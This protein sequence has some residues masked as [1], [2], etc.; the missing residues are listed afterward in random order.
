MTHQ[1]LAELGDR[2]RSIVEA[3][4]FAGAD[5]PSLR[6]LGR[7]LGI[8]GERVRQIEARAFR[9]MRRFLET[10]GHVAQLAS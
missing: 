8:S 4:W 7:R 5:G 6:T 3:R 9:K 1:A 10:R 2:E